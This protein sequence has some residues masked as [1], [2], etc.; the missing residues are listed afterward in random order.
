[1]TRQERETGERCH[2]QVSV[3][4]RSLQMKTL[5]LDNG[6]TNLGGG[7]LTNSKT[8]IARQFQQQLSADGLLRNQYSDR[9]Q[10]NQ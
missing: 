9:R 10:H 4:S 5:L 6:A 8:M 1:M 2:R 3:G 7:H